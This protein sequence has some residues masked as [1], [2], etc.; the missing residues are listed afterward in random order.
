MV[1]CGILVA[2]VALVHLGRCSQI[3]TPLYR[4]DDY[5][6]CQREDPSGVYCFVKVIFKE[7][8]DIFVSSE[9][10]SLWRSFLSN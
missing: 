3:V 6:R 5:F 4:Y 10:E 9:L 1:K 2:L 7:N 8:Q